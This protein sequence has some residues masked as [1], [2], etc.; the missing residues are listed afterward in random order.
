MACRVS[1]ALFG[2][3]LI[4]GC[5]DSHFAADDAAQDGG[6]QDANTPDIRNEDVPPCRGPVDWRIDVPGAAFMHA[7]ATREGWRISGEAELPLDDS[8]SWLADR[9]GA[10]SAP[11]ALVDAPWGAGSDRVF[12]GDSEGTIRIQRIT[13]SGE[14][15]WRGEHR[16]GQTMRTM[17]VIEDGRAAYV[18]GTMTNTDGDRDALVARFDETGSVE[19]AQVFDRGETSNEWV[20]GAFI[21]AAGRLVVAN[22]L[23]L[24]LGVGDPVPVWVFAL[25]AGGD[26]VWEHVQDGYGP[27]SSWG[28]VH[29][30][31]GMFLVGTLAHFDVRGGLQTMRLSTEG[32]V[33]WTTRVDDGSER[34]HE[35]R[36]V[37]PTPDGG[38]LLAGQIN[39]AVGGGL[40][41]GGHVWKLNAAGAVVWTASPGDFRT[42]ITN[43]AAFEDGYILVSQNHVNE[44]TWMA[45][46]GIGQDGVVRWRHEEEGLRNRVGISDMV[47]NERGEVLAV[48]FSTEGPTRLATAIQFGQRC[49]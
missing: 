27:A 5:Y 32:E 3:L 26:L 43:M 23:F 10:L 2:L 28:L 11:T 38:Y 13:E 9:D 14:V 4:C 49:R 18:V 39:G 45:F 40:G 36:I 1:S 15:D 46:V 24:G 22:H 20:I 33:L 31:A 17:E 42:S 47:P 25:S 29:D 19:W 12:A 6:V 35:V 7:S 48:G 44:R 30:D 8:T 21:D 16:H 37:M 34:R 41:G